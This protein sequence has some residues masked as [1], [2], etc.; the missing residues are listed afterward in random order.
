MNQYKH[1]ESPALEEQWT[2]GRR[3]GGGDI[4]SE[5]RTCSLCRRF[6]L[7]DQFSVK[8][9]GLHGR[10]SRCRPCI[11]RLRRD[12]RTANRRT[13]RIATRELTDLKTR[14]VVVGTLN[15]DTTAEFAQIFSQG[16]CDLLEKGEIK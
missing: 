3:F 8:P 12:K 4:N 5:G 6:R 10:D 1:K 9:K 2:A 13:K 14:S 11:V 7:W 16:I 15:K